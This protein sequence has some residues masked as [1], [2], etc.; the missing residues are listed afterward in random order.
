MASRRLLAS[1]SLLSRTGG[2]VLQ[3]LYLVS[4]GHLWLTCQLER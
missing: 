3:A 2:L 1:L 4:Y